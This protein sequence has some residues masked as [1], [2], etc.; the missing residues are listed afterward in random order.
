L[1]TISTRY[2]FYLASHGITFSGVSSHL[3]DGRAFNAKNEEA[4][5]ICPAIPEKVKFRGFSTARYKI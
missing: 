5:K 2:N 3:E 1:G 4:K